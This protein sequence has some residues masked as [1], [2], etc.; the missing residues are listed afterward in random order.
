MSTLRKNEGVVP[1]MAEPRGN[2]PHFRRAG[3]FIY[4]SGTSSRLPDGT[5]IGASVG[6]NG[7]LSLDIRRQTQSVIEN[8]Q[9]I[10]KAAGADLS[11]VVDLSVF[12]TNMDNF[13]QFNEVYN[14]FFDYSGPART[15][16]AVRSLPHPHLLI[17]IKAVA[18]KE[19]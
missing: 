14:Q 7:D 16:V 3:N 19:N 1:S 5:F 8:I 4:V 17:E 11:N 12:L 2:F 6:E 10:L 18:Y 9:E 13:D 15:T